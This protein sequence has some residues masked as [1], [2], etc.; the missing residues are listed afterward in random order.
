[1][2]C[3]DFCRV[4]SKNTS[5]RQRTS[6]PRATARMICPWKLENHR[7][8]AVGK[9]THSCDREVWG[10]GGKPQQ[11]EHQIGGQNVG[12]RVHLLGNMHRNKHWQKVPA[13]RTWEHP[14]VQ[15]V[16]VHYITLPLHMHNPQACKQKAKGRNRP[17]LRYLV[18]YLACRRRYS[19]LWRLDCGT[20]C[21]KLTK[22]R[23]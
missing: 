22:R 19:K 9:T 4:S 7:F 2:T 10:K 13:S 23:W 20:V 3:R 6:R 15:R 11:R 12:N 16:A 21:R 17:S 8:S 18:S 14:N 5:G 1:M